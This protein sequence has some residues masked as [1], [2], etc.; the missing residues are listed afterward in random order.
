MNNA[1]LICPRCRNAEY[2]SA[3]FVGK[4]FFCHKCGNLAVVV[5]SENLKKFDLQ[6]L[7][8]KIED[9][10][11]EHKYI[12]SEEEPNTDADAREAL[13]K[14]Y[15]ETIINELNS[16]TDND[17]LVERPER[18]EEEKKVFPFENAFVYRVFNNMY[19]Y[20]RN[21][22]NPANVN[23]VI[24]F[25]IRASQ[26]LLLFLSIFL[27]IASCI[28][29]WRSANYTINLAPLGVSV[30]L[31]TAQYLS[32]NSL[33]LMEKIEEKIFNKYS[34][35]VVLKSFFILSLVTILTVAFW[36]IDYAVR[37]EP[38]DFGF[39]TIN[40]GYSLFIAAVLAIFVLWILIMCYVHP[41]ELLH[42]HTM[43]NERVSIEF[44][45]ACVIFLSSL[46]RIMPVFFFASA[47]YISGLLIYD[48]GLKIFD[49][50]V[51]TY[52]FIENK[53]VWCIVILLFIPLIL[54]YFSLLCYFLI[55][56]CNLFINK[57]SDTHKRLERQYFK[58]PER[59][60]PD[61]EVTENEQ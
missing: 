11:K 6:K 2:I 33:E 46:M 16:N 32:I 17:S 20:L 26:Y 25:G 35:D 9:D 47:L 27:F 29:A 38:I 5:D 51:L 13:S 40:S 37:F 30:F 15:K 56:L 7:N 44:L 14:K 19:T 31:F 1:M 28:F 58:D 10:V 41:N 55:D 4:K 8:I 24:S 21:N 52:T 60:D 48:C 12:V 22:T 45:S 34:S 49:H 61:K 23:D 57:Y 50:K 59:L 54:Y 53:M 43:E 42:L 18:K 3:K 36:T 39:F